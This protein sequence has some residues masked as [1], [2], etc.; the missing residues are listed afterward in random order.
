MGLKFTLNTLATA[1]IA[2][3]IISVVNFVCWIVIAY[4]SQKDTLKVWLCCN[5]LSLGI[6][7]MFLLG[8]LMF[9]TSKLIEPVEI[10]THHNAHLLPL[11]ETLVRVSGAPS[12]E[13]GADLLRTTRASADPH[14]EELLHSV[15]GSIH[16]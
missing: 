5:L 9:R 10:L 15:G 2:A 16:G 8:A 7:L 11:Q 6:S 13:S 1:A 14:Q 12:N 4:V 3:G